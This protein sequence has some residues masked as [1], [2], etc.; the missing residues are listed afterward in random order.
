[1]PLLISGPSGVGK[2]TFI[3]ALEKIFPGKF[4]KKI[5]YTSRSPRDGEQDK[6]DYYFISKE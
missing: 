1:M 4:G 2:T 6:K 3:D 5:S